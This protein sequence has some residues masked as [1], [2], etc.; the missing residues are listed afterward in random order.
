MSDWIRGIVVRLIVVAIV[1]VTVLIVVQEQQKKKLCME[2]CRPDTHAVV[3]IHDVSECMCWHNGAW[4]PYI[5]KVEE[6][7]DE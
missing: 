4:H 1:G 6:Q 7:N 3:T 2:S 5:Q